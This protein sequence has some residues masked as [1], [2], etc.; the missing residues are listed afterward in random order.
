VVKA[1]DA[2]GCRPRVYASGKAT[3]HCPGPG[4]WRGD[5]HPSL[6]ITPADGRALVYCHAG[7]AVEDVLAAI[8]LVMADLFDEPRQPKDGAPKARTLH[9]A[10]G[11]ARGFSAAD[12]YI[13]TRLLNRADWDTAV[14]PPRFQPR[15]Q[16]E[17]A[18]KDGVDL[19]TVK[20]SIAH[21]EHHGWL[22]R[23]CSQKGC[24]RAAPHPGRGHG[25]AYGFPGVGDDCPGRRC[26]ERRQ[27]GGT[28]TLLI[29]ASVLLLACVAAA[30]PPTTYPQQKT[31]TDL[32][33]NNEWSPFYGWRDSPFYGAAS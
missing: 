28:R 1:L 6:T 14:I 16:R 15:S 4:H 5:E 9:N 18:A 2:A 25:V 29:A 3:A 24:T 13:Y 10:I 23:R 21:L 7:C 27:K 19:A 26:P 17:I 31:A 11:L 20:A 32:Q 33:R 12:R 8:G 30:R 22:T